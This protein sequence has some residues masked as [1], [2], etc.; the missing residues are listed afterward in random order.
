MPNSQPSFTVRIQQLES[1]KTQ[2]AAELNR[3]SSQVIEANDLRIRA[4]EAESQLKSR[5][6]VIEKEKQ[7]LQQEVETL[8]GTLNFFRNTTCKS[9]DEF[10]NRLKLELDI[11]K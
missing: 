2:L 9:V 4:E 3:L 8:T 11:Y 1:E 5:M 10:R 6:Q 7:F